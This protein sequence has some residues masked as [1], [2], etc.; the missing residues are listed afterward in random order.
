[1]AAEELARCL[2]ETFGELEPPCL[3]EL[4]AEDTYMDESFVKQVKTDTDRTKRWQDLRPMR[5]YIGDYSELCL[6]SPKAYQY[7]L[8][9]YLHALIDKEGDGFYLLGVLDSVWYE[10][11]DGELLYGRPSMRERWEERM[12]LLTDQQK[13]CIAHFLV[14]I[15]KRSDDRLLGK[16]SDAL[17][18]EYM[19]EKY[20]NAWL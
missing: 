17:R 9:A 15:L 13:K 19:L 11:L 12:A 8:P 3:E 14:E 5:L 10:D 4:A 2:D 20:W 18:I 7:Y 6:L 1:M 16:Y